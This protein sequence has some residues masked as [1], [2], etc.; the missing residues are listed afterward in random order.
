MDME[1]IGRLKT[2]L[3]ERTPVASV[4]VISSS[5]H[6]PARTGAMMLVLPG[7]KIGSVGGGQLEHFAVTEAGKLL[8]AGESREIQFTGDGAGTTGSACGGHVRLFVRV[9][10]N[11]PRLVILGAGHVVRELFQLGIHLGFAVVIIDDRKEIT[12]L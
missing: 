11:S 7:E 6:S 9:F 10:G 4:T 12:R 2:C 5:G 8:A 3:D 1:I